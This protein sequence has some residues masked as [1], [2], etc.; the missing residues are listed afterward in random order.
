MFISGRALFCHERVLKVSGA[1]WKCLAVKFVWTNDLVSCSETWAGHLSLSFS[2]CSC[3]YTYQSEGLKSTTSHCSTQKNTNQ[4]L[5]VCAFMHVPPSTVLFVPVS[6][7]HDHFSLS[8]RKSCAI[9]CVM[10][11]IQIWTNNTTRTFMCL[12]KS[13]KTNFFLQ[14]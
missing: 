6:Y 14:M 4:P 13:N 3:S 10:C 8:H 11:R 7:L 1:A 12:G 5:N 9:N 2:S